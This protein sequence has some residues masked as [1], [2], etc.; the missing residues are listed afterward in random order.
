MR[1]VAA[2]SVL[3]LI[4]VGAPGVLN[5]RTGMLLRAMRDLG[6]FSGWRC[7]DTPVYIY[8]PGHE[9]RDSTLVADPPEVVVLQHAPDVEIDSV[10]VNLHGGESVIWTHYS[11]VGEGRRVYE[12]SPGRI[13]AET[14]DLKGAVVTLCNSHIG[15]WKIVGEHDLG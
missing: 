1:F 2:L 5:P 3:I 10:S 13:E 14:Y 4:V 8:E 12:L 11:N 6:P 9:S 7:L 15:D